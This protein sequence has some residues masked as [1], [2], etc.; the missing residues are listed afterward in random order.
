MNTS[1]SAHCVFPSPV[2][3]LSILTPSLPERINSHLGP[4][5]KKLQAQIAA[6]SLPGEVKHL[7]FLDNRRRNVGEKRTALLGMARG[8]FLAFVDDDDDVSDDYVKIL[9]TAIRGPTASVDVITFQQR[10]IIEGHEGICEWRLGHPNQPF[11]PLAEP[12]N[13]APSPS[14]LRPP[15]HSCAWRTDLVR[16]IPFPPTNDGEDWA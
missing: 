8:R 4:L 15:W 5:W 12:S 14:F 6:H 11:R 2:P 16:G 1:P 9:V 10:A 3:L 7:V 13:S